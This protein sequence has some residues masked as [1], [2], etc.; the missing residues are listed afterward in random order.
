MFKR[1][2]PF[3]HYRQPDGKD[4]GPTCLRIVAKYYG[5]NIPL[6][7]IRQL[8]ETTREGSSLLGLSEAAEKM[9]F[10]TLGV[11]LSLEKLAEADLPCIL[12]WNKNHFVVLYDWK[13]GAGIWK[14]FKG[15]KHV[16]SPSGRVRVG[17]SDPAHGLLTYTKEEFL[18]AWIGNNV[19]ENT[20]EGIALLLEPTPKFYNQEISPS[21]G[22]GRGRLT[23]HQAGFLKK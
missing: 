19:T 10:R 23:F 1:I 22:G 12:H 13:Q 5:K 17:I 7:H 14:F 20:E 15:N 2:S 6:Q 11:K 9:G 16:P 21:L 3:P 18:K 8:S 4:C